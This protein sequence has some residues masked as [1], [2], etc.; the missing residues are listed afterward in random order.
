MKTIAIY[1]YPGAGKTW[2]VY[3]FLLS[4][5]PGPLNTIK[6]GLV[7]YHRVRDIVVVGK[8]DGSK[9]QGTDRLSM[10]V[11]PSFPD[12]FSIEA[13]KG[14]RLIIAEGDR[15]NNST[16][17]KAAL[18]HGTLERIKCNPDD[19]R[20]LLRQRAERDHIFTQRFLNAVIS[21]VDKHTF[22]KTMDSTSLFKYLK[23]QI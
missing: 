20:D 4:L 21:K 19:Y 22:D 14:T 23:T 17:L 6:I 13:Q 15:V 2:A 10:A 18:A 5:F 1:G 11:A 8:Y 16:F 7:E 3:K 12:F 9:F